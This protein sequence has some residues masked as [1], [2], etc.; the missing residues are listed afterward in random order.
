MRQKIQNTLS[1]Q[2]DKNLSLDKKNMNASIYRRFVNRIFSKGNVDVKQE[3]V[4]KII[5]K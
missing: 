5:F 3:M 4:K 2:I 1:I